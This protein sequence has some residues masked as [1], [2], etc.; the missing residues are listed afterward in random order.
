M[1]EIGR[2]FL[3][4]ERSFAEH[5]FDDLQGSENL[6]LRPFIRLDLLTT[7]AEALPVCLKSIGCNLNE[8]TDNCGTLTRE[9]FRHF[10][11]EGDLSL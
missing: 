4:A 10:M 9:A 11:F 7:A 6:M 2:Y 8:Y 1:L 5:T 3:G